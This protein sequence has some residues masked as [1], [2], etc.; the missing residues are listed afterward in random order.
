MLSPISTG[1]D[2]GRNTI[3][4]VDDHLLIRRLFALI[5]EHEGHLVLLA[6][7]GREAVELWAQQ[8]LDLILMDLQMPIMDGIAAAEQIRSRERLTG[9]R[10]PIMALTAND[11]W[12]ARDRCRNAG[13]DH[14]EVKPI[15]PARLANLVKELAP[16]VRAPLRP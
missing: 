3:L 12:L 1:G 13:F 15:A 8:S 16:L 11:N 6:T 2:G 4:V 14:F 7:N 5:L 10:V 9:A